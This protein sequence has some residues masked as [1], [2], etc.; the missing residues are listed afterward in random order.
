M[1]NNEGSY[2]PIGDYAA[3]GD[4]HGGALVSSDGRIDWCCL[5]RFDADP[6]FCRLLDDRKG[7]FLGLQ[8]R[9]EFTTKRAYLDDTNIVRT[10][11]HTDSG[12]FAVTDF[13][14][15]GRKPKA[16]AHDYVSL[17]APKWLIRRIEG[18]DGEVDIDCVYR[19]SV[20]FATA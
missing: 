16:S 13:M 5:E 1:D 12:R 8:P 20:A 3:I 19:P 15:V 7:G 14:P 10:D 18:I 9:A 4:C 17:S 6:V 11:F 2:R